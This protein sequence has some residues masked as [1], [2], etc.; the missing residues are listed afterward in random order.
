LFLIAEQVKNILR[1]DIVAHRPVAKKW[2]CKI[3]PLP[4]NA[5][6]QQ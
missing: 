2:L 4:Y 3:S 5:R 6:T 1:H